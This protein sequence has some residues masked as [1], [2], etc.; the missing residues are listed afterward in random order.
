L[1]REPDRQRLCRPHGDRFG[2]LGQHQPGPERNRRWHAD[3]RRRTPHGHLH[4][5]ARRRPHAIHIRVDLRRWWDS[6]ASEPKPQ[7]RPAGH[8]YSAAGTY[9]A[10][11]TV[12]DSSAQTSTATARVVVS[13][14]LAASASA[15]P[16]GGDAPLAVAFTGASTGGLAPFSYTWTFGD[17]TTSASLSPGHTY[18]AAGTYAAGF[19]VTDANRVK[20]SATAI[21]IVV[22]PHLNVTDSGLPTAGEAPLTVAFTTT[23]TGGTLGY[24]YAW[25]FGDGGTSTSQN[26]SHTYTAVGTFAARLTVTDAIGAT[27]TATA[28]TITVNPPPT[29]T[30][31]AGKTAGDAPLA[32]TFT[33]TASSGTAPYS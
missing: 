2:I 17:G 7:L 3:V 13:P 22:Q 26:P 4:R 25:T 6:G 18:S 23:P 20:V 32:V 16:T 9:T 8:T 27:A 5:H 24:S 12:R 28:L 19:S 31:S 1:H 14:S 29:A 11:L 15:T 21:T 33:G 10:T 30:A